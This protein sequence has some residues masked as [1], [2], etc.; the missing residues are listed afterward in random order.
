MG[1]VRRIRKVHGYVVITVPF[2]MLRSCD[3][4]G[5]VA[6]GKFAGFLETWA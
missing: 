3:W 5:E 4:A 2:L 6:Q 1:L